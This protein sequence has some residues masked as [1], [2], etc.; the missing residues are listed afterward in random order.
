[1]HA[2]RPLDHC[3]G[4]VLKGPAAQAATLC[5]GAGRA[6]TLGKPLFAIELTDRL[7][8]NVIDDPCPECR[9]KP[10]QGDALERW[11][12]RCRG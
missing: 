5:R 4:Y 6:R 11:P 2:S 12:C 10:Y 3:L 9:G 1:M 8:H 7:A